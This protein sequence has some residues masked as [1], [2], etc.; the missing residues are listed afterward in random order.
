MRRTKIAVLVGAL[1]VGG[2]ELDIVRNFPRLNRDEFEVV[3]VTFGAPGALAPELEQQGIRVVSGDYGTPL[4]APNWI[5]R[6]ARTVVY[7]GRVIPWI[8]RTFNTERIQIAHFY[9]PN[10]YGYG[11]LACLLMHRDAKRVM[12]RLSLNFYRSDHKILSWLERVVFHRN[13]DIAIGNSQP[14]LDELVDEGVERSRVRLLH[15]GIDPT[16][17]VRRQ[18]DR[19][20]AR[21]ALGVEPGAFVI[22]AVGNLHEYKGHQDLIEACASASGRL[23]SQWR[24]LIAGRDVQGRSVVL[25][26][27][28]TRYGL[29]GRV[30]FLGETD[31]VADLLFATD[32]FAHPSHHE[33]LPNAIIEAMAAGLP[34]VATAVG[35]IPEAVLAR[36][37]STPSDETGWLVPPHDPAAIAGAL[38]E[39]SQDPALRLRM[40]ANAR[41]RVVA[42]FSL[43]QSV[44][45][46]EKIYRELMP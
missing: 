21:Q 12:S 16:P 34:V 46:Y 32:V 5:L 28:V 37:A 36:G 41:S 3:V 18:G 14:I 8:G 44:G 40:G 43:E 9:L 13:L 25:E 15:N 30:V 42:E 27:L 45:A 29:E 4:P 38:L 20:R 6:R 2:A 26:E 7:M 10:A 22:T 17:F 1:E 19:E 23:P 24:L 11:M 31:N 35:G 33:G 39:A